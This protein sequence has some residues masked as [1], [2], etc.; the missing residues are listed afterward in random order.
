MNLFN[1]FK[2]ASIEP[3]PPQEVIKPKVLVVE[4][5]T[6]I[7]DVYVELLQSENYEVLIAGNGHEALQIALEKK[8]DVI[9]LDIIMPVM[10]GLQVLEQLKK[11]N[12]TN[13]VPVI[14]LT[15]AG[16]IDNM[17]NAKYHKAYR[18]LIKSNI[19]P[20]EIVRATKDALAAAGQRI[21]T[22]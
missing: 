11:N 17:E 12:T 3:P 8:P 18:F 16:N 22:I 4:D 5:E 6:D 19:V 20:A 14:V 10:D 13:S 15:N 7:R 21:D 1:L 2:K 9:I